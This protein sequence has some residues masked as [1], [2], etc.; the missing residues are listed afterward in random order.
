MFYA[1]LEKGFGLLDDLDIDVCSKS[2]EEK[3]EIVKQLYVI[4]FNDNSVN[5]GNENRIK[6]SNIVSGIKGIIEFVW[7]N[8]KV[9]PILLGM[10]QSSS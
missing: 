8:R 6:G 1:F 5:I 9:A 7:S 3:E 10:P 4:V 2:E